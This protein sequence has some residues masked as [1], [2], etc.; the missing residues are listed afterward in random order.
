MHIRDTVEIE[1]DGESWKIN[2]I[3]F[4]EAVDLHDGVWN[5]ETMLR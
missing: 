3:E 4:D 5:I 2:A 1:S